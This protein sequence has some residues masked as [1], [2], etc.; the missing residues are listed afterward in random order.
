MGR[1]VH[2]I[3]DRMRGDGLMLCQGKFGL[4]VRKN[5]LPERVVRHWHRM[6][7]DGGVTV[8]RGVQGRRR[9]WLVGLVGVGWWLDLVT[10]AVFSSLDISWRLHCKRPKTN[11]TQ[12]KSGEL[13]VQ[14]T[15]H[16][17]SLLCTLHVE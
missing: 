16:N 15:Q 7:R 13:P 11:P 14:D 4:D 6:P 8:P 17:L 9:T 5:V 10:L 12:R 2:A 1:W 3:C